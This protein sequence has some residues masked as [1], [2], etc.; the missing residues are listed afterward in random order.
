MEQEEA[1]ADFKNRM[2]INFPF[3]SLLL[4]F[5]IVHFLS[6]T[7]AVL[8]NSQDRPFMNADLTKNSHSTHSQLCGNSTGD[9]LYV[10]LKS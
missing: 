8:L 5:T 7:M 6:V 3:L 4:L 2:S 9:K 10:T 1:T